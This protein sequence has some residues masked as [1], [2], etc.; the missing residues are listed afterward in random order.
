MLIRTLVAV[1]IL[2]GILT[3]AGY[4]VFSPGWQVWESPCDIK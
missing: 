3:F 1:V 4:S 2:L